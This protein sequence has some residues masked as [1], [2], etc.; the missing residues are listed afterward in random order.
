[1]RSV[2]PIAAA[3]AAGLG[4]CGDSVPSVPAACTGSSV[5]ALERALAA[6]PNQVRL[7]DHSRVSECVDSG[8]RSDQL[9]AVGFQL[10]AV[11]DDLAMRASHDRT[12]ALGLGYLIGAVRR[13]GGHV[14][15]VAGELIRRIEND[16][17][18]PGAAAPLVDAL[19]AGISAGQRNG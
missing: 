16:G 18:L 17:A 8:A 19:R 9:Q 6:A 5:A 7:A 11:A 2:L 14:N 12:A 1:V 15:G 10:T 3:L 13:G 4:A